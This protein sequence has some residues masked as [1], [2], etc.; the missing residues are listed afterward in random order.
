M[1]L[2]KD[3]MQRQHKEIKVGTL[4]IS[5]IQSR[6]KGEELNKMFSMKRSNAHITFNNFCL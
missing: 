6:K 2:W 5:S 4:L 3:E 1:E